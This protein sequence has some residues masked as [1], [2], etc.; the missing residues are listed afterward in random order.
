LN[1]T[2]WAY[3]NHFWFFVFLF[4]IWFLFQ[5][6]KIVGYE[7]SQYT[8]R[9]FWILVYIVL[10]MCAKTVVGKY[11]AV[12]AFFAPASLTQYSDGLAPS[13]RVMYVNKPTKL[14]GH[15]R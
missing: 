14:S 7:T 8:L 3:L 15:I 2:W 1:S 12:F 13:H 6:F 10:M 11:H 4:F 9:V 5:V